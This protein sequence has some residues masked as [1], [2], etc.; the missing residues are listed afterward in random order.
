MGNI[1]KRAFARS[2]T[3]AEWTTANPAIE[4]GELFFIS[5][6]GE[7][8]IGNGAVFLSTPRAAASGLDSGLIGGSLTAGVANQDRVTGPVAN[9]AVGNQ[10][11][12]LSY[13][14]SPKVFTAANHAMYSSATAAAAT[15]TTVKF[16]LFTVAA[17]GDLTRVAITANQ[18]STFVVPN[19]RYPWPYL[20]SVG[21][22]PGQVYASG[23]LID[24]A[25]AM[26]TV[27]GP[28]ALTPTA[29]AWSQAPKL[30]GVITAQTDI[31][32]TY[33]AG[34]VAASAL[35]HYAEITT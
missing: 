27:I 21:I 17:N 22:V 20:A 35:R 7:F 33:T 9:T 34:Q 31:A 28:T 13:V 26:P 1:E 19:T 32:A 2:R 10:V 5:D 25:V 16:G 30:N 8:G 4:V 12:Y 18:T 23:W 11:L 24:S 3:L 29:T 14:T 6:T 15:P